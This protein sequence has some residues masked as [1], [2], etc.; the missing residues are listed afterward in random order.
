MAKT[1]YDVMLENMTVDKMADLIKDSTETNT[2]LNCAY[3]YEAEACP[4][5]A[6]SLGV[7]LWLLK[8]ADEK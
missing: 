7:K 8:E 3:R 1:N 2:C 4:D 6:C 5:F